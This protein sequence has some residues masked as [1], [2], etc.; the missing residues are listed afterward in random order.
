MNEQ[1]NQ[2]EVD[3]TMHQKS[4]FEIINE[5]YRHVTD[6]SLSDNQ[7]KIITNVLE[8]IDKGEY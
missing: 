1:L 5:F 2:F 4:D 7:S 8:E 3:P 6:Q